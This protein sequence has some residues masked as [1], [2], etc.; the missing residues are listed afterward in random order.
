MLKYLFLAV[1]L[2]FSLG[3]SASQVEDQDFALDLDD[4]GR[5]EALSDGLLAI[6]YLF[7]FTGDSLVVGATGVGAMRAEGAE[8]YAYAEANRADMDLDL[9]GEVNALTDGLILIRY[10]FGFRGDSLTENALA[11]DAPRTSA[12]EIV[13]SLDLQ[14]DRDGDNVINSRDFFPDDPSEWFDTDLDGLGNNS[15][16]DDDGDGVIDS[17]DAFPLDRNEALDSDQDGIGNNAD[18]DDDNDGVEDSADW[19]PLDSSESRDSDSDGLGDNFDPDDDNDFI[20]DSLDLDPLDANLSR[21]T[22]FDFRGTSSLGLSTELVEVKQAGDGTFF[23]QR[24]SSEKF[25]LTSDNI[26][27]V[28]S[29]DDDGNLVE[30]PISSS[31]TLFAAE[32]QLSPDKKFLYLLTSAHIQ[33]LSKAWM[34]KSVRFTE[35]A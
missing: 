32:A 14:I 8:V 21:S 29:F 19:A 15:D 17:A 5:V 11:V 30:S 12:A 16:D 22:R 23:K 20:P 31:A 27:N 1:L 9:D 34:M 18:L 4:D 26:S 25:G 3:T 10:L 6:R 13:T 2:P 33:E 7:G 35:F 28:V 24:A